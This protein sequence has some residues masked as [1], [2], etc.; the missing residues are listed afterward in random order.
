MLITPRRALG[1]AMAVLLVTAPMAMA[2]RIDPPSIALGRAT[3]T[4]VVARFKET[5]PGDRL[6][7]VTERTLRSEAEVPAWID[8]AKPD[9]IEAPR[10]NERY[11]LAYTVVKSDAL[12]RTVANTRGPMFLATP[13]LEP[14]LWKATPQT[15]T[16]VTWTIGDDPA[17]VRAALPRLLALL[18]DRDPRLQDFAA[19]E[20]A[21]RPA[22]LRTLDAGEQRRLRGFVA[23]RSAPAV[24]RARVLLAAL[25]MPAVGRSQ[26]AWDDEAGRLL[27][28]RDAAGSPGDAALVLDAFRYFESRDMALPAATLRRWLTSAEIA[29]VEAALASMRQ[30]APAEERDAVATALA[31][32][33]LPG[34]TRTFLLGY[35]ERLERRPP[36]PH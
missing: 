26:T 7:F 4:L 14:A 1:L 30:H 6:V 9:L 10:V 22:L 34:P 20:L 28:A 18:R 16:L 32:H 2:A 33:D 15:E 3:T 19:A 13:G 5:G 21:Y 29:H 17:A 24:A 36:A 23:T 31:R 12:K 11:V 25:Q 35:R 8:I 27:R